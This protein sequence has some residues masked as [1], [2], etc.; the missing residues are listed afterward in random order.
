MA[1][2]LKIAVIQN[3]NVSL[4]GEAQKNV[5]VD[6]RGVDESG[7]IVNERFKK[8]NAKS[9]VRQDVT[10]YNSEKDNLPSPDTN[11]FDPLIK[12]KNDKSRQTIIPLLNSNSRGDGIR[13]ESILL[14][15]N[16]D[17]TKEQ[18]KPEPDPNKVKVFEDQISRIQIV[19][20]LNVKREE[21]IIF[22]P[23]K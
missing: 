15:I 14:E 6:F 11:P 21:G 9:V 8:P 16:Q 10:A 18:A 13:L 20:E 5:G 17:L 4:V 3:E 7:Y 23:A 12:E 1:D 19:K 22:Q 2:E